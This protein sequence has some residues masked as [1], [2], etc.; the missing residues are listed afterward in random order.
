MWH[1]WETE[2]CRQGFGE[3]RRGK[4]TTWKTVVDGRIILKR[5]FKKWDEE[6][7]TGL[8]WLRIWTADG[9]L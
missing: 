9:L 7:W 3:Q 8:L 4:E 6:L 2:R 5:N 1:V